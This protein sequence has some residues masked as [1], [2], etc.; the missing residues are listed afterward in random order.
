MPEISEQDFC[1]YL[2]GDLNMGLPLEGIRIVD[3][4]QFQQGTVCTEMLS[5]WGADVIKV[6]PRITGEPG[7]G[8]NPWG[9]EKVPVYFEAYNRNKRSITVDLKKEKG[10]DIVYRLIKTADI[11]AQNFRPGVAERL[12]FGY[13]ALS[14]IN[15]GLIY[16]SGS[17]FGLR[18]PMRD[19]PG[20]DSVGQAM[21][22]IM[23]VTGPPG[24]P[25]QPIG[26]GIGDQTGGYL[27][28]WGALLA[29]IDRQRTGK[30]QEVDVSLIGSV[31]AL[32]GATML[33]NPLTGHIPGKGRGR[34]TTTIFAC[35]FMA[36]DGKSFIIQ[37][38]GREKRDRVFKIAGLDK[39]PRFDTREK[40][41]QRQD[42]MLDA[43][44]EVFSTKPRDEWLNIL[45]EA[46]VV[47]A[48]VYNHAEV[49]SDPQVI[50]NEYI[51]EIDHPSEGPIR[52]L[53]NPIH[54][55]SHK[56]KIGVA[57]LLGQ[58]TDEILREAG[59]GEEEIL[60]LKEEKVI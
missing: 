33:S 55:G 32:Q 30:G 24:S 9:P 40:R 1:I 8:G 50:E 59:Y 13:K 57:P 48:P 31:V 46:D 58:H 53:G 47:C 17:G 42:E 51:V 22:G 2:E 37:T 16:L 39:D 41:K 15:P 28:S 10:K 34:I 36:A 4:T 11:F 25:D 26:A 56:A 21:G 3:F 45:V 14:D 5:D 43:F 12:G 19:R 29:L 54:L 27:M 49:A 7:R 35:S 60:R 44:Q 52:V 20:F 18:G 23:S 6:E 38:V